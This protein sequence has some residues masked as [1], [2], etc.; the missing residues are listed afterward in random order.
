V[1]ALLLPAVAI[2]SCAIVVERAPAAA[3][4]TSVPADGR[5]RQPTDIPS[6]APDAQ[7]LSA[8]AQL[9]RKIFF[10]RSL[11]GSGQ[12]ACASCHDP[13]NAYAP[14][15][16]LTVQLG[17]ADG[18]RAGL[19]AVPSLTYLEHTPLF[20]IGPDPTAPDDDVKPP[21][22]VAPAGDVKVATIAKADLSNPARDAAAANV[23]EGGL[24]WDGRA[25]TIQAQALGPLLDPNEMNNHGMED[26]LDRLERTSYAEEMKALFGPAIFGQPT[27]AL[28]ELLFA[29]VRYQLE[30][31][32]FHPYDSKYDAYLAGKAKLSE[33][34][35]RGLKLFEDPNKGNCSS[36]HIDKPGR[37]GSLPPAFTDYE[38][39]ALGAPRNKDIP[40]NQDPNYF[41]LG[42]CGPL[43]KDYTDTGT[44]CGLFKTPSLRNVA[45]RK[46][47]FHNGV[48]HSL[49]EVLHFYVE[50]ETNPGK[51]YPKL[52]NGEIDRYN[53]LPRQY[54]QNVDV[55]DAPFDRKEGD[56]PALNEAEIADVIAFLGTLTDGYHAE[57]VSRQIP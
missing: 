11:S 23:P 35:Q 22:A 50:R 49:D 55:A 15:N 44:Y 14:A 26:V 56:Q 27:L 3:A 33:T 20:R 25:V 41:D 12:L 29:I 30:E 31:Q 34:E 40:A 47:F 13:A 43:R 19:R 6:T 9:G 5:Q 39:E 53:D 18:K 36:C 24:D 46:V 16:D 51:W 7:E 2:L 48:F 54:K 17:G 52:A 57:Q 4:E 45:T 8:L 37:N 28:D 21:P 38:F 10:D 1:F 32:S 42:L